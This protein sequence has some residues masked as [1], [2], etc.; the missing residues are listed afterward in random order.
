[1]DTD[2]KTLT[3][4]LDFYI[5]RIKSGRIQEMWVQT[6]WIYSYAKK[7]WPAMIFIP[8]WGLAEL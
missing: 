4:R 5:S 6:K 2:K 7:Y 3:E 1:M 8:C